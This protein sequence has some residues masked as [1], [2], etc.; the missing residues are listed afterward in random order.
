M[1]KNVWN[2]W[3]FWDLTF[4]ISNMTPIFDPRLGTVI[5]ELDDEYQMQAY[6]IWPWNVRVF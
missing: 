4:D 6:D 2:E 5:L 1:M 3:T